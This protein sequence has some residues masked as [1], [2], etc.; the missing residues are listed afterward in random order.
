MFTNWTEVL[1][2]CSQDPSNG[3][4]SW[5]VEKC[6]S[7]QIS[8]FWVL[9]VLRMASW[10]VSY[11]HTE[12]S[13][14]SFYCV[15]PSS[16]L[17]VAEPHYGQEPGIFAF[18]HLTFALCYP[19]IPKIKIER[20]ASEAGLSSFCKSSLFPWHLYRELL[21]NDKQIVRC[22]FLSLCFGSSLSGCNVRET[23][24]LGGWLSGIQIL[25]GSRSGGSWSPLC[26]GCYSSSL[27]N[28]G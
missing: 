4:W 21:L 11:L 19:F 25:E 23:A 6:S 20:E 12:S 7:S 13:I 3:P 9:C 18:K 15:E 28:S 27:A 26:W 17:D 1:W 22:Y 24:L 2:P 10:A 5:I 8:L 16:R 14:W